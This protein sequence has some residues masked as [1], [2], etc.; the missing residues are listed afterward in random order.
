MTASPTVAG[1]STSISTKIK[2]VALVTG[3]VGYEW[4]NWLFYFKGGAAWDQSTGTGQVFSGGA[5]IDGTSASANWNGWTFGGGAEWAFL[6]NWSAKLEYNHIDF[7]LQ[8]LTVYG[9]PAHT[10]VSLPGSKAANPSISSK[11][12]SITGP[13][14]RSDFHGRRSNARTEIS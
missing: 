9:I 5:T 7:G 3:R 6:P 2:D 1:I 8:A 12:A 4:S 10:Q 13:C 14:G 11:S